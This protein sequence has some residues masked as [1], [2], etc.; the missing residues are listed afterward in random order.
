MKDWARVPVV[1]AA[2]G[3]CAC[4]PKPH[5]TSVPRDS[6]DA[7]C[8]PVRPGQGMELIVLGSGGPRGVGRAAASY[9]VSVDGVP[10]LLIDAGPGSFVR[11]GETRLATERLDTVLLTHLHVDHAGDV[12][13]FVKS[14]DLRSDRALTF[15]FSGPEGRGAYPST[16]SFLDRLF[17]PQG[18]FAYL[19]AFRNPLHFMTTDLPLDLDAGPTVVLQHDDLKVLSVAVDHGEVPAL[20]FRVEHGGRS[21]VVSGDLASKRGRIV[22]LARGADLLVYDA[23]VLDPPGSPEGLYALHTPP[24]RIGEVAAEAGVKR[25]L[26][27]H[28]PPATERHMSE[29]LESVRA[30]FHGDVRLAHDCM[31]MT[32][33][34]PK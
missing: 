9:V 8:A 14:Q 4:G 1:L 30:S 31:Q 11:L 21:L 2:A 26:L 22:E 28:I 20:A 34:N 15:R 13:A 33:N 27:S 12:P 24:R 3:L 16:S 6:R 19:A 18:A 10:R 29:V 25:L 17:G 5:P 23:A 32:L 7:H